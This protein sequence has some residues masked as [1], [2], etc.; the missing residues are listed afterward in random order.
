MDVQVHD[1]YSSSNGDRWQLLRNS[2]TGQIRVRH[3]PNTS[4]GGRPRE[5]AVDDFLRVDGSG[6]EFTEIR[7]VLE[8]WRSAA[9]LSAPRAAGFFWVQGRERPEP[10]YWDGKR[11]TV[12]A[13]FPTDTEP[14]VMD[15]S[16]IRFGPN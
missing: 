12:L 2:W 14:L 4:S 8:A 3:V 6:P 5:M 11:W 7:R 1:V 13:A 10:A 9:V 15:E 16:P